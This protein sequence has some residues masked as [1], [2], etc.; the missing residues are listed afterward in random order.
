MRRS[1]WVLVGVVMALGVLAPQASSALPFG[2]GAVD[3]LGHPAAVSATEARAPAVAAAPMDDDAAAASTSV[4]PGIAGTVV[5][6][7]R[8][9]PVI[10][11]ALFVAGIVLFAPGSAFTLAAGLAYGVWVGALLSVAA[12][13]VAATIHFLVAR[14]VLREPVRRRLRARRGFEALDRAVTRD[15]WK[16]VGLT[17]VSALV[18][19]AVQN[20]FYA[21]TDVGLRAFVVASV[22]GLLP[23]TLLFVT[24]GST[25]G[26]L[27]AGGAGFGGVWIH[28][29]AV[30]TLTLTVGYVAHAARRELS[31][32]EDRPADTLL[33]DAERVDDAIVP[34]EMTA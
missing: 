20:L 1:R 4:L 7:A 23:P 22:I 34:S 3:R 33:P 5:R 26:R 10:F 19:G 9:E 16:I 21:L 13:T 27:L 12:T 8:S 15:G 17:R 18:P 30:A 14:H 24:A 2:G 28:V 11:F 31:R 25:G 32:P 29:A 6:I